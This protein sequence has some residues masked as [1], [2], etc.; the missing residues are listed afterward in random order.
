MRSLKIGMLCMG[1]AWLSLTRPALA[2]VPPHAPG[3]ICFTP[4]LLVLGAVAG[5]A[6]RAV[7]VSW[8]VWVCSRAGWGN[9]LD[10][11]FE[12]AAQSYVDELLR[13][14]AACG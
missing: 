8:T 12:M 6:R 10:G 1:L 14:A 11:G 5:A 7:R 4:E 9:A 3:T 2:Q 13:D